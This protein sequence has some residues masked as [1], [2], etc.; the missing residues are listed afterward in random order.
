MTFAGKYLTKSAGL[1]TS[2][3]KDGNRIFIAPQDADEIGVF[4]IEFDHETKLEKKF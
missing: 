3:S 2:V 4:I 1:A